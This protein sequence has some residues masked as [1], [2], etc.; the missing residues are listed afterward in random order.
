MA[1]TGW[2]TVYITQQC[3]A[4]PTFSCPAPN[5]PDGSCALFVYLC[6]YTQYF[7][8]MPSSCVHVPC[9][10]ANMNIATST[11]LNLITIFKL[12]PSAG[13]SGI[14]SKMLIYIKEISS[15]IWPPISHSSE[16]AQVTT[17]GALGCTGPVWK[18]GDKSWVVYMV[19]AYRV[20]Y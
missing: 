12:S 3:A 16:D 1:Q 11:V 13:D 4:Y 20:T 18:G 17:D 9:G 5:F 8:R 10:T 2:C 7:D 15:N 19:L 14:F 6:F